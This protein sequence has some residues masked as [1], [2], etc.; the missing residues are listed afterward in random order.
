M[1]TGFEG[2]IKKFSP[3]LRRITYRLNGHFTFFDHDDLYQEALEHLWLA[4]ESGKISDKTD[5]YVLQGCYYHLKNY[6]RKTMDSVKLSSLDAMMEDGNIDINKYIADPNDHLLN[7]A[8]E[9]IIADDA[10]KIHMSARER[11]ILELSLAG[12]T[13][14]EIGLELGISHVMVVKLKKKMQS[15]FSGYQN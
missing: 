4:Y 8:D 1:R 6:I 12:F 15:R 7:D 5:S 10:S 14:R 13:L 3:G 2:I 11:K 9:S